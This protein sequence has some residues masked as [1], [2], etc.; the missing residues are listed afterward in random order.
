MGR[1]PEERCLQDEAGERQTALWPTGAARLELQLS[2]LSFCSA[3]CRPPC[4]D[5]PHVETVVRKRILQRTPPDRIRCSPKSGNFVSHLDGT[6][7]VSLAGPFTDTFDDQN[8][9]WLCAV[10]NG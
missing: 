7:K 6:L 1:A 9:D 3:L 8:S 4:W 2:V 10:L 5:A